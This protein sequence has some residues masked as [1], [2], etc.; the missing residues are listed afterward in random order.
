MDLVRNKNPNFLFLM[1]TLCSQEKL[2]SLKLK[3]GYAN[4]FT[5]NKVGR[6]GG[7]ALY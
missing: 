5:V 6:N 2:E 1:K 7:L 3:F 4:L